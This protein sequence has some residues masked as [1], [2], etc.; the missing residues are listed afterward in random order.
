MRGQQGTPV[1]LRLREAGP[2]AV[3]SFMGREGTAFC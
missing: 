2:P 3:P 1:W